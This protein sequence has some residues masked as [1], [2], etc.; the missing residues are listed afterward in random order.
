[1]KLQV[2]VGGI[3]AGMTVNQWSSLKAL[4]WTAALGGLSIALTEE[5]VLPQEILPF[6]KES[7]GVSQ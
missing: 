3:A 5:V 6:V 1:M 4:S 7:H 2:D